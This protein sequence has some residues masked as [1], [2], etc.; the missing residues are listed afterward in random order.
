MPLLDN[1]TNEGRVGMWEGFAYGGEGEGDGHWK[2]RLNRI[3]K[4]EKAIVILPFLSLHTYHSDGL[5]T[6]R[7][8]QYKNAW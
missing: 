3:A 8:I 2:M 6:P 7:K 5:L 1:V 4:S